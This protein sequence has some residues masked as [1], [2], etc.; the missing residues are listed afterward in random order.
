MIVLLGPADDA[1]AITAS[2]SVASATL[3]LPGRYG[4]PRAHWAGLR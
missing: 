2:L 4:L 3:T 1:Q